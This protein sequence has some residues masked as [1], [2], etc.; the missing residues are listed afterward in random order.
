MR[1]LESDCNDLAAA[2]FICVSL[3]CAVF[4]GFPEVAGVIAGMDDPADAPWRME[5]RFASN[6][7]NQLPHFF[8]YPVC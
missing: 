3:V 6:L 1:H 2:F 5:V 8:F 7:V 4:Q